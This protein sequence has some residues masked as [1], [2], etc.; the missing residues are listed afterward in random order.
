MLY[1]QIP[2]PSQLFSAEVSSCLSLAVLYAREFP[3]SVLVYSPF[4]ANYL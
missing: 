1:H 2:F 3:H 4:D